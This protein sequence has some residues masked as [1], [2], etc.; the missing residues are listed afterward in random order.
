M[1]EGVGDRGSHYLLQ[2]VGSWFPA[3]RND[4]EPQ[5]AQNSHGIRNGCV[6]TAGPAVGGSREAGGDRGSVMGNRG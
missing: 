4:D 2:V 5:D 1:E 3:T 6:A